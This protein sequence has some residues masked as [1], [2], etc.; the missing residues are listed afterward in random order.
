MYEA[1]QR[2]Y[3]G[4]ANDGQ[5]RVNEASGWG[6]QDAARELAAR[7]DADPTLAATLT[8]QQRHLIQ[9]IKLTDANRAQAAEGDD[10]A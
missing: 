3:A 8:P 4:R 7:C 10:A 1:T 9:Q 2:H 5:R 6:R